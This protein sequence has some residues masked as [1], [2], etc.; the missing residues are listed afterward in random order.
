GAPIEVPPEG[1]PDAEAIAELFRPEPE[2]VFAELDALEPYDTPDLREIRQARLAAAEEA[3]AAG[4]GQDASG[5][6]AGVAR[7]ATLPPSPEQSQRPGG[8]DLPDT[9][10]LSVERCR[11]VAFETARRIA[12]RNG[13]AA[14]V[15]AVAGGI[16]YVVSDI[17]V[18]GDDEPVP[19][20]QAAPWWV[21]VYCGLILE[22]PVVVAEAH[23]PEES[24]LRGALAGGQ[25][26]LIWQVMG[27]PA[28][29]GRYLAELSDLDDRD[30]QLL[31]KLARHILRSAGPAALWE[32]AAAPAAATR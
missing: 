8:T 29:F 27:S 10:A 21:L 1:S 26:E 32:P 12:D 30:F 16:G 15:T 6:S 31:Q 5:A 11:D 18:V 4:K 24:V 7:A 14:L 23:L 13:F 3:A 9:G 25:T 28:R 17:I 22:L 20:A 2:D 19:V